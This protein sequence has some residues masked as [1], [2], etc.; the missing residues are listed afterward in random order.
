MKSWSRVL[1]GLLA[2][3]G[4]LAAAASLQPGVAKGANLLVVTLDTT[5]PDR[6]GAYGD[7]RAET[8]NF[9]ALAA[10]GLKYTEAV[11]V[12]PITL[13][14]H[15]SLF[16][17]TYPTT[18]GVRHN[19][20]YKLSPEASTLAEL[21]AGAGYETAAFVSA[22]VLDARYGL[23][24]G[25]ARYDDRVDTARGAGFPAGTSERNA[26]KVTDAALTW[27]AERDAAARRPFFAWVHYFDAHAP[28]SPPEPFATRFAGRL[29]DG[30]LAFVDSQLGRLLAGLHERGLATRTVVLVV[31]DHG[32]SLGE[33]GESTH[34][35]F[36]YD[37]TA[38]VP[39][40]LRVP[41]VA[42]A[43]VSDRL[44][45]L[46][47]VVP[48]LVD[49][50]GVKDGA[51]REGLSLASGRRDGSRSVYL[52]SLVPYLDF[53][54]APLHALRRLGE[55]YIAAPRPEYY[56]LAADPVEARNLV[57]AKG[58]QPASAER[59]ARSVE[60]LLQKSQ[61][62]ASAAVA[63]DAD[64]RARVEALGYLG[65][66]GPAAG[67]PGALPDP[68]DQIQLSEAI[69]DANARLASGKP[70]AALALLEPQL[71]VSPRDRSLLQ[72]LAKAYLRT[73]RLAD[74]ER[75]LRTFREI[76]PKAD[77]SL[78][79]AQILI[80]DGRLDEAARILDEAE[81]LDGKHG[82][83]LIARGDLLARQGRTGEARVAYERAQ[84]LDPYRAAGM[85]G[86]R[87]A[88]LRTGPTP[89]PPSPVPTP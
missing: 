32:E 41:G 29:Y 2:V 25:F 72:A 7:Q 26:Q 65:G 24:Q 83:V 31:G 47:D 37:S 64:A 62:L 58:P 79:L 14:A 57:P 17:G 69:I 5:R 81:R 6:L 54:W 45:S 30:E 42:P 71:R 35:V 56:D 52:E 21:L 82:G 36:V 85:A 3:L 22:F 63:P 15:S 50:L 59:L 68:K 16:T 33:H 51:A 38:R 20:E 8:P 23:D 88:A 87:L 43:V 60:A 9:D 67:T 34:S 44:V 46:V 19:A 18:H 28:Y 39:F 27:L 76:R 48:T 75:V 70:A 86:A 10:Q 55:K 77:T 74:A 80:L 89:P 40:V 78:L 53:G 1:C 84:K 12:A 61:P 11:T 4:P 66:A 73:N 49:L 13:V